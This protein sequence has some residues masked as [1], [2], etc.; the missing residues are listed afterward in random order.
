[1]TKFCQSLHNPSQLSKVIGGL[2]VQQRGHN[3][4]TG[5]YLYLY[6]GQGK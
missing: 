6:M 2:L 5:H 4:K 3:C 1:M